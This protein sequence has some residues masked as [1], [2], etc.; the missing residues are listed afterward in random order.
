M[1]WLPAKDLKK[2]SDTNEAPSVNGFSNLE[3]CSVHEVVHAWLAAEA[4]LVERRFK[5]SGLSLRLALDAP[6]FTDKKQN[7][8]RLRTLYGIRRW[9]WSEIPPDTSWY[10]SRALFSS[11]QQIVRGWNFD[12]AF[13]PGAVSLDGL[14]LWGHTLDAPLL[15]EGNHRYSQWVINGRPNQAA[16]V[17]V[18]LSPS[19]YRWFPGDDKIPYS[20]I[21]SGSFYE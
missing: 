15:L 3:P 6:D 12:N 16:A 17:F 5:I 14:I 11:G 1:R 9:L 2:V 8:K 7:Q 20:T 13:K 18:G 19:N 4:P 10:R 21:P